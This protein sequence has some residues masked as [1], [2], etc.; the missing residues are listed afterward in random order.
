ML[1][2]LFEDNPTA[3]TMAFNPTG[4]TRI[5]VPESLSSLIGSEREPDERFAFIQPDETVFVAL[6][7]KAVEKGSS[8][9]P[10]RFAGSPDV[11]HQMYVVSLRPDEEAVLVIDSGPIDGRP[12]PGE[13]GVSGLRFTPRRGVRTINERGVIQSVDED[14]AAMLGYTAEDLVGTSTLEICHPDFQ[15]VAIEGWIELLVQTGGVRRTRQRVRRGDGSWMWCEMIHTNRLHDLGYVVNEM[16]DVS[17]EMEA[18]SKLYEREQVLAGLTELLPTGVALFGLD[19][20]LTFTNARWVE[21]VGADVRE[22]DDFTK[23]ISGDEAEAKR[24]VDGFEACVAHGTP[25]ATT[26]DLEPPGAETVRHCNFSIRAFRDADQQITGLVCCL[27]DVTTIWRMSQELKKRAELD[28]LT[29]LL[30]RPTIMESLQRCLDE[31]LTT[32]S[33][34]AVLFCDLNG[35]KL[36]NDLLGHAAGDQLLKEI[37]DYLQTSTR[38]GDLVGRLGGDEFVIVCPNVGSMDA[39]M[40]LAAR[41]STGLADLDLPTVPGRPVTWS[42]G[43]ASSRSGAADAE[44]LLAMADS[45]MYE[46]KRQGSDVPVLF[47]AE[48][49]S[50]VGRRAEI[51][52]ALSSAVAGGSIEV[53]YQSIVDLGTE[54][55]LGYEALARW[56]HQGRFIPPDEFIPF[57]EARGL[58]TGIGDLVLDRVLDEA[59]RTGGSRLWSVNLSAVQLNDTGFAEKVLTMLSERGVSPGSLIFDVNED[60]VFDQRAV[61]TSNLLRLRQAGVKLAIDDFGTKHGS[62][63]QLASTPFT[64]IKIDRVFT[65]LLGKD[66]RAEAIVGGIASVGS[67]L[68][69]MVLAEGVETEEQA[70]R[71]AELG[72]L[73]AQGYLYDHPSPIPV[74][75]R[76][77]TCGSRTIQA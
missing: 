6:F 31:G 72:I 54:L 74:E 10:L 17:A 18:E 65:A 48:A 7:L 20:R 42:A 69:L 34:T 11:F 43:L 38:P 2:T 36:V 4:T 60:S 56:R 64:G 47:D 9:G 29:G 66:E 61:A 59:A 68:G 45:A 55:P 22:L 13:V 28:G 26:I 57:A 33:T 44:E 76:L 14:L 30:N 77:P 40:G 23:E 53:H 5:A 63:H 46:Q 71:A 37:A 51:G 32:G 3:R 70:I 73:R 1:G 58:I 24:L 52:R 16:I 15:Q 62:L 41:L 49:S 21:A 25:F 12:E 35:F 75:H 67:Q 19:R 39:V 50:T 27:E 8:G